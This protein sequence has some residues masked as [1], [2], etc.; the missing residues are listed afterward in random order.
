MLG[1][2]TQKDDSIDS[3]AIQGHWRSVWDSNIL[4]ILKALFIIPFCLL[5]KCQI[6]NLSIISTFIYLFVR[7]VMPMKVQGIIFVKG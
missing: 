3:A 5:N 6:N 7:R 4:K 1:I 2:F